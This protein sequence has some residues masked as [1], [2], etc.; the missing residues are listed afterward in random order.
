MAENIKPSQPDNLARDLVTD[1]YG[2]VVMC[3]SLG[4]EYSLEGPE[5]RAGFFT[6]GLVDGLAG[7]ADLNEDGVIYLNELQEYAVERVKSLSEDKQHPVMGRP[8]TLRPFPLA[9]P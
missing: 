4:Q 5:Q 8:S 6:R 1:D 2:V 7:P 3:S 9:R